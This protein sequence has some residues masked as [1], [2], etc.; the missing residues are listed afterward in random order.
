[1]FSFQTTPSK[2]KQLSNDAVAPLKARC[3]EL[4]LSLTKYKSDGRTTAVSEIATVASSKGEANNSA[5]KCMLPGQFNSNT[6]KKMTSKGSS[7]YLRSVYSK[8]VMSSFTMTP[9]MTSNSYVFTFFV[10]EALS[11]RMVTFPCETQ[12]VFK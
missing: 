11:K 10:D 7:I 2:T 3:K 5:T 1:M 8:P 9:I 4:M 12:F 6:L